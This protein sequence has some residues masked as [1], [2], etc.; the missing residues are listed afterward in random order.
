ML[1]RVAHSLYWMARYIERAENIA[2]LVDVNLQLLLDLRELDD[3][4]LAAYWLPIVQATGDEKEFL[5]LHPRATGKTV[6][7]FLVFQNENPNSIVQVICQARENARMVRDQLTLELWEEL[8]RLYLFVRSP[9]ARKVWDRS[10][11]EFFQEIKAGSL[12]LIGIASATLIHDEGWWFVQAGQFLE[13]ADKTTR[14]LDVRHETLPERGA[15]ES[16][17]Q[18]NTLEWSAV[19]R[20]CSAWDAYKTF[21]GADVHPRLIAEFLLF[22]DSFPRSVRFCVSELNRALRRISGVAEGTFCNDAEKLTGRFLA[23][24]QFSTVDEIFDRGLH[25]Y[26]DEAQTKLNDIGAALFRSYIFQAFQNPD[27]EHMVQQEEQQQQSCGPC[28]SH[29]MHH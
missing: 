3:K 28:A 22:N 10:P 5:K 1:S 26:L 18:T 12:H 21:Y 29:L 24:L 13:R 25:Q 4:K 27:G 16:V 8:N 17:S 14:I 23:E 9:Q 7:E 6:T 2:R 20:S 19:L 11:S 15:P